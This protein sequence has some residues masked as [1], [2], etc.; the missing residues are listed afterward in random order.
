[1]EARCA[2]GLGDPGAL[3]GEH[4]TFVLWAHK[5]CHARFQQRLKFMAC[6]E[7]AKI[8]RPITSG[9]IREGNQWLKRSVS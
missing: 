9:M 3:Q 6:A 1:M 4:S 7:E 2:G 5:R 8:D